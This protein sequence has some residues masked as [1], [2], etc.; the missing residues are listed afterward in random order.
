MVV[1][2]VVVV[3]TGKEETGLR[4]RYLSLGEIGSEQS[5]TG[6]GSIHPSPLPLASIYYRKCNQTKTKK[7]LL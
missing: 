7:N 3:V 6:D 4:E 1:G 5:A 2:V